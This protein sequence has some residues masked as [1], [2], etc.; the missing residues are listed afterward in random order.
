MLKQTV[1]LNLSVV[2]VRNIIRLHF[3]MILTVTIMHNV[4]IQVNLIKISKTCPKVHHMQV[5]HSTMQIS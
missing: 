3:T 5:I 4:H 1:N 2:N